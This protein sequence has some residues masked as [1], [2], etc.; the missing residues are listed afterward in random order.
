MQPSSFEYLP[1][2]DIGDFIDNDPLSNVVPVEPPAVAS[3]CSIDQIVEFSNVQT[4]PQEPDATLPEPVAERE[5]RIYVQVTKRQ[6]VVLSEEFARHGLAKPVRYYEEKTRIG[7]R[8]LKRLIKQMLEGKDITN[9]GKRGRKPK[10]TP[11]LLRTMSTDLSTDQKTLRE[12]R[13]DIILRNMEA[14]GNGGELLP[15]V[16]I[17]SL[18][19]YA[20]DEDLMSLVDLGP[21]SFTQVT[22]RGPRANTEENKTLRIERRQQLGDCIIAGYT[23]VF[24]DES[25]WE[26][27]NVRTRAWGPRGE[28]IRVASRSNVSL[29]CICSISDSRQRHCKIFNSTITAPLFEAYMRELIALYRL[30]NENV[31][32]VMDNAS[33]HKKETSRLCE[34]YGCRVIFNAP[35]SPECNPIEMVFGI[36]KT[37]VGKLSNVDIFSLIQN[38]S[39]CFSEIQPAE[40]KRCIAHFLGPVTIKIMNRE[41]L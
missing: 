39:R 18:S 10:H 17:S 23:V 15:E 14:I 20:R 22:L 27:G 19:R 34:T 21:L 13:R 31:V 3:Q 5:K 7:T 37:R 29:S 25:H 41:D 4:A 1:R 6:R 40:V 35:Y 28:H 8:S 36:W 33:I 11:E 16:S 2:G 32:F 9:P 30:D 12:T 38:I 24:V 26:V